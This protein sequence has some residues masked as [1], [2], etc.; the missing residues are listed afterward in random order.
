MAPDP[1]DAAGVAIGKDRAFA[2]TG[3][4]KEYD[5]E[6]GNFPDTVIGVSLETNKIVDYYTPANPTSLPARIWIWGT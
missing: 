1:G 6:K 5:M 4:G 3:D 2:E